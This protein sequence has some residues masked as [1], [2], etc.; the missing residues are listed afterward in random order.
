MGC[1]VQ[2]VK[3]IGEVIVEP[4]AGMVICVAFFWMMVKLFR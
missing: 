4:L 2:V 1:D 3:M